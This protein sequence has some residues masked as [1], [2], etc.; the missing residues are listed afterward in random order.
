MQSCVFISMSHRLI[1]FFLLC[2][3]TA[4]NTFYTTLNSPSQLTNWVSQNGDPCGQ[5]WLGITCSDSR[6]I[7]M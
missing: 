2:S 3:V 1:C 5:S 7:T 4:L 6:V